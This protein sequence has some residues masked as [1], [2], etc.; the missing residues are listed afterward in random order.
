MLLVRAI[1]AALAALALGGCGGPPAVVEPRGGRVE[2]ELDDF[3]IRP[4]SARAPAGR[5]TFVVSNRGRLPHNFRVRGRSGDPVQITTL[6]PGERGSETV[7]LRR[8][9]YKMLCSVAN[10]E[11]LGMT[12]RLVVR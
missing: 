7:T 6:L 10:H 11:Q 12:G 9:D 2:L 3:L 5:L 4:Q 1:A 8:G